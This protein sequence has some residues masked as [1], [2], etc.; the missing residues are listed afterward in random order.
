MAG[1][2]EAGSHC[3][4][5]CGLRSRTACNDPD[6]NGRR[7]PIRRRVFGWRIIETKFIYT[8]QFNEIQT[9]SP[10]GSITLPLVGEVKVQGKG[11]AQVRDELI[12]LYSRTLDRPEI[13]VI[14]RKHSQRRVFVGGE[15]VKPGAIEMP[16]KLTALQAIMEAGGLNFRTA[17]SKYIVI[18]RQR[19]DEEYGCALD[20]RNA[21][22][23]MSGKP[24]YL[25]PQ[26]IVF[27]PRSTITKVN[28]WID[29]Y[30]NKMIPQTGASMFFPVGK[31]GTLIGIDTSAARAAP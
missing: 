26:D 22:D 27:V 14:S 30:I 28:Q 6:A 1:F 25:E 7:D 2:L 13:S 12:R 4:Q 24:F 15:V 23:G 8:P 9:V 11:R 3:A 10:E 19:N 31:G 16:G 17:S 21:L 5:Y 29:Q 20:L 18:I